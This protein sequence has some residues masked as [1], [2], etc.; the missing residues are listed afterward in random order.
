[1]D[2]NELINENNFINYKITEK[3]LPNYMQLYPPII[4]DSDLEL[5]NN[6]LKRNSK[7]N[8]KKIIFEEY[9]NELKNDNSYEINDKFFESLLK[10]KNPFERRKT[11]NTISKLIHNSKLVEKFE[12]EYNSD[13][14][15][16]LEILIHTCVRNLNYMKLNKGEILFKIGQLG[17]MGIDQSC[18]NKMIH[19]YN[20]WSGRYE[21]SGPN[22]IAEGAR[23]AGIDVDPKYGYCGKAAPWDVGNVHMKGGAGQMNPVLSWGTLKRSGI[24]SSVGTVRI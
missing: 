7:V 15:L 12:S 17:D 6:I 21:I 24:V 1:M 18:A 20:S 11:I 10:Q 8:F 22:N 5:S 19:D 4:D 16:D 3:E 2:E 13:K 14:K 9:N 23:N